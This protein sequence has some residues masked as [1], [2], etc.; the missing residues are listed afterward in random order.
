MVLHP[1]KGQGT[2]EYALLLMLC[3]IVIVIIVWVFGPAVGDLYSNV[4]TSI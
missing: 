3:V 4:I 1:Q 2:L